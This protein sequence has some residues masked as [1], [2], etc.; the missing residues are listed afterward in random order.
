MFTVSQC[1]ICSSGGFCS[2]SRGGSVVIFAADIQSYDRCLL[3]RVVFYE[4][5]LCHWLWYKM[6]KL[7]FV[8]LDGSVLVVVVCLK[9]NKNKSGAKHYLLSRAG[10]HLKCVSTIANMHC[11]DNKTIHFLKPFFF[12]FFF[13]AKQKMFY[14]SGNTWSNERNMHRTKNL[15]PIFN[16]WVGVGDIDQICCFILQNSYIRDTVNFLEILL[17][18]YTQ[19]PVY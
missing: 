1:H 5:F 18:I 8:E 3:V 9:K 19:L 11:A 13:F 16:T 14:S 17:R 10:Y 4:M 7:F 6:W 12:F 2:V 15:V